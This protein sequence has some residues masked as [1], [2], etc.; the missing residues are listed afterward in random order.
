MPLC[1]YCN[2]PLECGCRK[3]PQPIGQS[4]IACPNR[5]PG[6]M[7]IHVMD[8]IGGNV[9]GVAVKGPSPQNTVETGLA[10]FDPVGKGDYTAE[11][12]VP[13]EKKIGDKYDAPEEVGE[14]KRGVTVSEGTLAY[15]LFTLTRKSKLRARFVYVDDPKK[16]LDPVAFTAATVMVQCL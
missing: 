8:D 11:L 4:T 7:W 3:D 16:S 10:V 13:L 5:A 14:R 6:K 12:V 9:K 15:V 2:K 1:V